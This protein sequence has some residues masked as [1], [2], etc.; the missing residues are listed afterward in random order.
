M[1]NEHQPAENGRSPV[2]PEGPS[3]GPRQ[4]LMES[5]APGDLVLLTP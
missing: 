5:F 4:W 1:T 3:S 2:L